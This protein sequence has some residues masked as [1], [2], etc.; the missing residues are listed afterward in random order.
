MEDFVACS[1]VST[2]YNDGADTR[3][4]GRGNLATFHPAICVFVEQYCFRTLVGFLSLLFCV[5]LFAV[6]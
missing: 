3:R 5:P 2:T 6:L 1:L 4:I